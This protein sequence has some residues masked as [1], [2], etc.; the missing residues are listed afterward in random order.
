MNVSVCIPVYGVEKYIERCART[1]FE[2]TMQEGIEFIFVDDCT[3]DKSMDVLQNVLEEYPNRK[4]QVKIITHAQNKGL[5]GA[6]NTALKHVSGDYIIHCD[7]DDWV[8]PQLYETMYSKAQETGADVVCC[9][10]TLEYN[11]G[12]QKKLTIPEYSVRD[13]FFRS[14]QTVPFNSVWNKMFRREIALDPELY[15]PDHITMAEDLLRTSQMFLKCRTTAFCPDVCYHYFYSNPES[16]TLN[17]SRKAFDSSREVLEILQ[18]KLP[19][20]YKQIAGACRGQILFSALRMQDMTAD[21]FAELFRGQSRGALLF[22]R[23]IPSVK[24]CLLFLALFS[25]PFAR[26]CATSLIRLACKKRRK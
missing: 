8:D 14:F 19:P 4:A 23:Q 10:I 18:K 11:G 24:R 6:R 22:N 5:T 12:K 3:P 16:S 2:Q 13:L 17:F 20:E 15:L 26:F 21:E 7:S 25:Y 1:L 9:G